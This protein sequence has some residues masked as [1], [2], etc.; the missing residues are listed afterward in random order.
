M[1][2]KHTKVSVVQDYS[3][4]LDGQHV[5]TDTQVDG[6]IANLAPKPQ[7]DIHAGIQTERQT[8]G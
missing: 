1:M 4:S 7:T 5:R 6:E 8:E 2:A 3:I